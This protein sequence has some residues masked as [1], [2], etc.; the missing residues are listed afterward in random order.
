MSEELRELLKKIGL[1]TEENN[2]RYNKHLQQTASRI[3]NL[4]LGQWESDKRAGWGS[5]IYKNGDKYSGSF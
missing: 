2:K 3:F 1:T 4:Y 5:C